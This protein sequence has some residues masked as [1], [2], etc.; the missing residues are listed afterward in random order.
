MIHARRQFKNNVEYQ[1]AIDWL[2][3]KPQLCNQNKSEI[4]FIDIYQCSSMCKE[5]FPG[6]MFKKHNKKFNCPC[7]S[8][9]KYYIKRI[10]KNMMEKYNGHC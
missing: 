7:N 9:N 10:I 6:I 2:N 8:L 5:I 4:N 1:M 3:G